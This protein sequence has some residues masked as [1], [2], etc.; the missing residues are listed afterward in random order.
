[1]GTS[2]GKSESKTV[3]TSIF[4]R[5]IPASA[6]YMGRKN[7]T[8][9]GLPS[10][11]APKQ[12]PLNSY[13]QKT[14]LLVINKPESPRR[15]RSPSSPFRFSL[16]MDQPQ[17]IDPKQI[18]RRRRAQSETFARQNT[19]DD[20]GICSAKNLFLGGRAGAEEK[21]L[22]GGGLGNYRYLATGRHSQCTKIVPRK[23]KGVALM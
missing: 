5:Q 22:C 12:S 3:K 18:G 14:S 16:L 10:G 8:V 7:G 17:N 23:N 19:G 1:M 9:S 21:K 4:I 20:G 2:G 15:G 11:D 6:R 13:V